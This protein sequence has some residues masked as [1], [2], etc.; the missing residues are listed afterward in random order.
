MKKITVS[1]ICCL[2][3][4][5]MSTVG[6]ASISL[7]D[8]TQGMNNQEYYLYH[9]IQLSDLIVKG[10]LYDF[11]TFNNNGNIE[12]SGLLNIQEILKQGNISNITVGLTI[13]VY[14]RGGTVGNITT[15]SGDGGFVREFTGS[16]D[17]I[18]F[19]IKWDLSGKGRF[20]RLP[21]YMPS[22]DLL[23]ESISNVNAGAPVKLPDMSLAAQ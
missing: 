22:I 6:D 20:Y 10:T 19:L 9:N 12:T 1:I 16:H 11:K 14:V 5:F 21:V 17:G 3:I 7:S 4:F 2:F 18:F 15:L 13:P 8:D 23:K